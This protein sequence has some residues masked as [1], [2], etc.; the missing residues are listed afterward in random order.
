MNNMLLRSS[1][2]VHWCIALQTCATTVARGCRSFLALKGLQYTVAQ[3]I[4]F[5]IDHLLEIMKKHVNKY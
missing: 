2:P 5:Q 4:L 1:L 3:S